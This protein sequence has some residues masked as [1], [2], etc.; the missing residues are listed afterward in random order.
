[1]NAA[2]AERLRL[3]HGHQLKARNDW[4][5]DHL[6][7]LGDDPGMKP[8][9]KGWRL[10]LREK[11]L[12]LHELNAGKRIDDRAVRTGFQCCRCLADCAPSSTARLL[13]LLRR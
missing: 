9:V 6:N 1:M 12:L 7:R 2:A 3:I 10:E 4:L 5:Q 13:G 11:Q 8:A